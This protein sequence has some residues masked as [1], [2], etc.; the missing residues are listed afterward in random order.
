MVLT[1]Q[2]SVYLAKHIGA[3]QCAFMEVIKYFNSKHIEMP[4]HPSNQANFHIEIKSVSIHLAL[5]SSTALSL[6]QIRINKRS[7]TIFFFLQFQR[8]EKQKTI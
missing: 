8:N 6:F 3:F 1:S 4:I 5:L 2:Y 7:D